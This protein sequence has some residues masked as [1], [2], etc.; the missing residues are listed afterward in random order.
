MGAGVPGVVGRKPSR[1]SDRKV[2]RADPAGSQSEGSP[3]KFNIKS[4][5]G[6]SGCI[7]S[8]LR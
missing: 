6:K 8:N 7:E 2:S 3:H 4:I 1:A 5:R